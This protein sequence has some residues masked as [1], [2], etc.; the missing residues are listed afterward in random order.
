MFRLCCDKTMIEAE[1]GENR[2]P[3]KATGLF[4]PGVKSDTIC[5]ELVGQASALAALDAR[6]QLEQKIDHF[7]ELPRPK[8]RS[9]QQRSLTRKTQVQFI[10]QTRWH[11]L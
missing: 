9:C 1:E 7:S 3:K 6:E 10:T 11:G 4:Q 5:S 2:T 8:S